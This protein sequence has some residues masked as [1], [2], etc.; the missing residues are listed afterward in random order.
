MNIKAAKEQIKYTVQA[1]LH[2]D[3][4]GEYLIPQ[5]KQ[6]PVFLLGAPGIG[7]T[8]IMEQ[9]A[10]ELQIGFLSYS[11]THHTRQSAL[12]LP[13][14]SEKEFG[15]RLCR[16]SEYTMSEIIAAVYETMET[17]Q[18]TE[19]ILFLD[20]INC[21][22]ETLA[23]AMLQF[24]QYK[25]FGQHAIPEGWIVVTAGNPP[26]YNRSVR[27]FDAATMDRLKVMR[28]EPDYGVWRAYAVQRQLRNEII[29][30]LDIKKQDFY[31]VQTTVDGRQIVTPRA[32]EDLSDMLQASQS[33]CIPV[34]EALVLQYIQDQRIANDFAIY[35]DLYHKYEGKYQIEEI[36]RGVWDAQL[37]EQARA[38]RLDERVSLMSLLT[39]HIS[40][41]IRE[42]NR[43]QELLRHVTEAV[44]AVKQA[45][46]ETH[47]CTEI[48]TDQIYKAREER[49]EQKKKRRLSAEERRLF[50]E[51]IRLLEH[52]RQEL[53]EQQTESFAALA[54][55]FRRDTERF[56]EN[57]VR[58][59]AGLEQLF[60]FVEDAYGNDNEM[61]MVLSSL[62]GDRE[63]IAFLKQ[64]GCEAYTAHNRELLYFE[65]QRELEQRIE[66]SGL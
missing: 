1:Y 45:A 40:V 43:Q 60:A 35:Y 22:S 2:R 48:L 9:I 64:F 55:S 42:S 14:I 8:A 15:G 52:Y 58:I 54:Q 36:L 27:E 50:A 21:V 26:E 57:V 66:S 16:V 51:K 65:R 20:E 33:L 17:A 62:N 47:P 61:L 25:R 31:Q 34:S 59:Q 7:K 10:E 5:W 63:C 6:R 30:Y 53:K 46:S 44:R 11:M 37:L 4:Y 32:W 3:P 13:Y 39:D 38:A 56:K 12:G 28:A 19:G 18:C 29:S 41:E 23:P 24:L 49:T